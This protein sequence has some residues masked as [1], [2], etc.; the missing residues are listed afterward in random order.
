MSFSRLFDSSAKTVL[1]RYSCSLMFKDVLIY[2]FKELCWK[3]PKYDNCITVYSFNCYKINIAFLYCINYLI[4]KY[5]WSYWYIYSNKIGLQC[6]MF[7][8]RSRQVPHADLNAWPSTTR[9]FA[10]RRNWGLEPSLLGRNSAILTKKNFSIISRLFCLSL[11]TNCCIYEIFL[12]FVYFIGLI[13]AFQDWKVHVL[14]ER[15]SEQNNIP[16]REKKKTS[17]WQHTQY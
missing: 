11:V 6:Y 2:L 12:H 3:K 4:E 1:Y 17:M 15:L 10:L 8:C 9:F 7:P 14:S 5:W 13:I 16:S